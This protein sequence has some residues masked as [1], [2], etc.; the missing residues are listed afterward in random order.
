MAPATILILVFLFAF[1][2]QVILAQNSRF[3]Q[4]YFPLW[5]L[6]HLS[7]DPQGSQVQLLMDRSSGAGFRSKLDYRSG[8]FHIRMKIPEK[9]TGGIVTCFYL[10]SAP[11]NQAPGNH[12]E[13][14]YEFL[15]TNGTVQTNVYNNDEGHRE[16]S[17]NLW[18][19]PSKDFHTYEFL[20][21]SHQI[22]FLVDKIPIRVFKNNRAHGVDYPATPMHIEASIWNADWAGAVDW[23]QAPFIA[24]YQDF[25]FKA[26]DATEGSDGC[27]SQKYYWNRQNYWELS[28]VQKRSMEHYRKLFMTYDY[29][30]KPST[31]KPECNFNV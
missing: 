25:G 8:L 16:Q 9:R 3:D 28:A 4:Y 13:I 7:V 27:A 23:S 22:V 18:F 31:R 19:N 15:G 20:W 26:C 29:C 14:D 11:D 2:M 24:H 21:N 17:F 10:T 1:A 5:G 12:Y 30:S 6:N